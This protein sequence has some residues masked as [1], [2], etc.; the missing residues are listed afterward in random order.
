M[1]MS[2]KQS[3]KRPQVVRD[4]VWL[5]LRMAVCA[6][7]FCIT[8][9]AAFGQQLM[10]SDSAIIPDEKTDRPIPRSQATPPS[11]VRRQVTIMGKALTRADSQRAQSVV[12][13][14]E[15]VCAVAGLIA[16]GVLGSRVKGKDRGSPE[17]LYAL[18]GLTVGGRI[19]NLID[20]AIGRAPFRSVD[21]K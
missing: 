12:G 7:T 20:R 11:P 15:G 3:S 18:I 19:G 2:T 1:V 21:H 8:P 5:S 10:S 16:G 13:P 14:A 9:L 6:V 17:V 4:A